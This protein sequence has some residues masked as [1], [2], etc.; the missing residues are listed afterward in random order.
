M[1]AMG[2]WD[3]ALAAAQAYCPL[4]A[5][6]VHQAAAR[7]LELLGDRE[8]AAAHYAAAETAAVQVC[9]TPVTGSLVSIYLCTC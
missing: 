1:Q 9:C 2:R 8:A 7:H 4:Q 5:R 6:A 3:A